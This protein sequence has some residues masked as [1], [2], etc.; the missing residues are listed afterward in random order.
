[1]NREAVALGTPVHTIFSGRMGAVDADLIERGPLA[2]ARRSPPTWTLAKARAPGGRAESPRCRPPGRRDPGSGHLGARRRECPR[3]STR[4][5]PSSWPRSW[6]C[7]SCRRAE[8]IA[9]RVG[10]IDVPNERSLHVAPTPKLGGLAILVG[11]LVAGLL[12]L[13]D[14]PGQRGDETRAIL[15]GAVAI[16]AV[17]VIDDIFDLHAGLKLAGPDRRGDHPGL[18]GRDGD[19]VHAALH[20]RRRARHGRPRR[21]RSTSARS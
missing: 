8:W 9:R 18:G 15:I 12:F 11:V 10:A 5:S 19:G 7:C 4:S 21:L 20:R 1:M 13:P 14:G 17:G 16:A 2:A 3:R 6:R